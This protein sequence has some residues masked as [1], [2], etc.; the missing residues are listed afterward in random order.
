AAPLQ[1]LPHLWFRNTWWTDPRAPKP[2][3]E[4]SHHSRCAVIVA[5]HHDLGTRYLYCDHAGA[6]LFTDN[7]TNHLRLWG[8]PNPTTF[9]KDGINASVITGRPT[10]VTPARR[11]TRAAGVSPFPVGPGESARVRLGLTPRPPGELAEPFG[12]QFEQIF[13][14]RRRETDDFY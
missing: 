4:A 1:I 11:G 2:E 14:E 8:Q 7:E 3:L 6:L 12:P 9:R 13:D 5:R 10:A